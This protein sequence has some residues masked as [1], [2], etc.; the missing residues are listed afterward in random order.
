MPVFVLSSYTDDE[1]QNPKL[2][3]VE[4]HDPVTEGS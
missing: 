1:T 3:V 4:S 2:K